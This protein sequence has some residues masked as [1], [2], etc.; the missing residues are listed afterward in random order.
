M[1]QQ[2]QAIAEREQHK[3]RQRKKDKKEE[4][5]NLKTVKQEEQQAEAK[6][7]APKK[8][9]WG[10]RKARIEKVCLLDSSGKETTSFITE[11]EMTIRMEYKVTEIVKNAVFGIGIFRVDGVYCYG[12]NTRIDKLETF[13]IEKDGTVSFKISSVT[14]LPGSY[15]LDVAIESDFGIPVDFYK[16]ACSFTLFSAKEDEG[17]VRLKHEWDK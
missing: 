15:L 6:E 17:V 1:G 3:E 4:T 5:Q 16:E 13:D 9:R 2:R 11:D 8:L 12:T 10:N 14:L 7:T